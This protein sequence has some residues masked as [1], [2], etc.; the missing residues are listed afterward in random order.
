MLVST[1]NMFVNVMKHSLIFDLLHQTLN[2][3]NDRLAMRAKGTAS[4]LVV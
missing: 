2:E 4:W 3:K 1:E